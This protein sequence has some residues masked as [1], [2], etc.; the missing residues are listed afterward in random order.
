MTSQMATPPKELKADTVESL[1]ELI[2]G[3]NDSV[4]YHLRAAEA[5]NDD[6]ITK[7][8][9]GIA[10][11]RQQMCSEIGRHVRFSGEKPSDN[12]TFLGS[13]RTVWTEFRSALNSGDSIVVLVEAARAEEVIVGR[14]KNI[15]RQV[16][17][18]PINDVLLRVFACVN[19][20]RNRVIALR[21]YSNGK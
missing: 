9:R 11:E 10:W 7:V 21:D 15:L 2:V 16:A 1:Q 4:M 17:G 18:N 5:I 13:L 14:L 12:G 8:L 20:G 6:Y 19:N 3:L